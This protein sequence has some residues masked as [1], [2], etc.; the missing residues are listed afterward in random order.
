[1]IISLKK[2]VPQLEVEKLIKSFEDKGLKVTMIHGANYNVFGLVGDTT[3]VDEKLIMANKYVD[4]VSRIA[5]PYKK[6]NRIFHPEDSVIDVSSIKIGGNENIVIIGGPCSVEGEDSLLQ[7]AKEV[8][9]AGGSMLRGGAYKPRTSPYAFQGLQTKGI[10]ILKKAKEKY[11][12]P[13]VSELMS[14]D[15]I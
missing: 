3:I 10:E 11:N 5:A 4:N 2:D 8:K 13:I 6:A 7:I 14:I 12:L 15:K 1:M 9:A